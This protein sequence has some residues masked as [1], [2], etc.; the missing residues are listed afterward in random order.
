MKPTLPLVIS[1]KNLGYPHTIS[2]IKEMGFLS[3]SRLDF[4]RLFHVDY[5]I[6]GEILAAHDILKSIINPEDLAIENFA[7]GTI[8][9]RTLL[10]PTNW[11]KQNI[12]ISQLELPEELIISL[13]RRKTTSATKE[14]TS[15]E[16][17]II[18][19]GND[20]ILPGDEITVI[21][22]TKNNV[23]FT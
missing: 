21:G 12:P 5:F 17:I 7:H 18:P 16:K 13:I 20:Y 1:P 3:R 2:R 11:K 15:E 6:A 19:H 9:M 14:L 23:S 22:E 4:S 8:Q 10:V